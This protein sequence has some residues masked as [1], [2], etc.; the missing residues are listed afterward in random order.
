MSS[1]TT[2]PPASGRRAYSAC[3]SCRKRKVKCQRASEHD[4][5]EPCVRC[6]KKGL[7]CEFA[8]SSGFHPPETTS[9]NPTRPEGEYGMVL[10]WA[11]AAVG[12]D[13]LPVGSAGSSVPGPS[14]SG[15]RPP[16]SYEAVTNFDPDNG[17]IPSPS[18]EPMN[19]GP[20]GRYYPSG[21]DGVT[22]QH[23]GDHT[24]WAR[25]SS[26]ANYNS[27]GYDQRWPPQRDWVQCV[28]PLPGPCVCG[29]MGYNAAQ[30][31]G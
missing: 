22:L 7:K 2:A 9:A 6:A 18:Y 5:S 24:P 28:C 11:P 10:N 23:G 15:W 4:W 21:T 16:E 25:A 27:Q 17:H 29:A 1:S 26:G 20:M 3:I 14:T 12:G 30:Y 8:I 31:N 13:A 19:N